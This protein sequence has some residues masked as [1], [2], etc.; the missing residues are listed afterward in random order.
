MVCNNLAHMDN[1]YEAMVN[2]NRTMK[3][4]SEAYSIVKRIFRSAIKK[5]VVV[6]EIFNGSWPPISYTMKLI[7]IRTCFSYEWMEY[8]F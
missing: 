7:S 5:T 8:D 6:L 4:I 2:A 1:G 3:R